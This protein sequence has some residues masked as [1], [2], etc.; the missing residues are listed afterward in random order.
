MLFNSIEFLLFFLLLVIFYFSIPYKFR[1]LLLLCASYYFYMSWKAEYGILLIISTLITYSSGLMMGKTSDESKRK[2]YLLLSLFGNLGLLFAFKYVNFFN[3]SIRTVLNSVNIFF[4]VPAFD[5]LLPV[6]ISFYIFKSLSYSLDVYRGVI[7]PEKHP[8]IFALYVSF[9]PQLLAGPIERAGNLLPQFFEKHDFNYQQVTNGLILILWGFFKKIVIADRLALYVDQVYNNPAEHIGLPVWAATY[10]FAFQ[11]F[12]DFSAYSDIAIGAA[13]IMGYKT[14]PNFDRPYFSKSVVEFWRRWHISL[15]TWF[16]D[17]LFMPLNL[18]LR[19]IG[20]KGLLI[21][22]LVTFIICGL[23]H[24]AAWTFIIWG[25]LH[26]IYLVFSSTTKNFRDRLVNFFN[27]SK[28]PW[29]HKILQ[30]FLT[31]HLV[32]FA[33]IFFRANSVSDAFTL[34]N[35]MFIPDFNIGS[36]KLAMTWYEIFIAIAS[37][38]FM[39]FIHFIERK[40]TL[41]SILSTKPVWLRWSFYYLLIFGILLFGQFRQT[42]FIYFQ[43]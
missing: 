37:I 18:Q 15:S 4:S 23:W 10:F 32:F 5:I 21:S 35:N 3:D 28:Y 31:F 27:L 24:G 30:V 39:E 11:I 26:G 36:L 33:W 17:Y 7:E 1:W 13:R 8:G 38:I 14:M 20:S 19:Y 34:I 41:T 25:G 42:E 12:C 9:F 16:R 22:V 6:G 2:K 43:F 29:L 40:E